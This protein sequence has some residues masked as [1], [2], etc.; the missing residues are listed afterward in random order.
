[1]NQITLYCN[2]S[3]G[4]EPL[5]TQ[6]NQKTLIG[7]ACFLDT[8]KKIYY[9]KKNYIFDDVGDNI[10]NLNPYLGDLTGLY[11]VWKNTQDEFVGVN[12]YRR[13][14]DDKAL[15]EVKFNDNILYVSH[16]HNF[17]KY[18]VWAQYIGSHS[19]L[20]IK[21]LKKAIEMKKISINSSMV[22]QLYLKNQLSPCNSFFSYR[23]LF[24]NV[25]KI[26]F[27]IILELYQGTQYLLPYV[28]D[29]I[30]TNRDNDKRL[31]A[32]LAERILNIIYYNSKYFLGDNVYVV[33]IQYNLY[34]KK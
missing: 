19:A 7:G 34:H 15:S 24:D 6:G 14:Y 32:F 18:S 33:P 30:H 1:M 16:F 9:S 31:L 2:A 22:N 17:G 13:F 5:H 11:W 28:Q 8:A 10:S 4:K 27:D 3:E 26:L 29:K 23:N 25:C 21:I 12:Q 20:G